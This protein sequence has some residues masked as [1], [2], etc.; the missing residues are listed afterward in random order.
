MAYDNQWLEKN[1]ECGAPSCKPAEKAS[2]GVVCTACGIGI[3][4]MC[5]LIVWMVA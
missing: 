3:V 1:C 5:M 2:T 4:L